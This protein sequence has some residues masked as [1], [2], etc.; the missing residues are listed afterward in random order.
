MRRLARPLA[1]VVLALVSAVAL[2]ACGPSTPQAAPNAA[3]HSCVGYVSHRGEHVDQ[4]IR[5]LWADNPP[6]ADW[7]LAPNGPAWR[8][9]GCDPCASWSRQH[10]CARRF[11][12][13]HTAF[14]VLG[15]LST[16]ADAALRSACPFI[17]TKYSWGYADCNLKL[18]RWKY[19][20]ARSAGG[21]GRE[22][23]GG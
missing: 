22:P 23:W 17:L 11:D 13:A 19:D 8:E 7:L 16:N 14:G 5:R 10:D 12:L 21:S 2:A 15:Y 18:A 6:M 20:D 4:I 9:S 1:P 3:Q